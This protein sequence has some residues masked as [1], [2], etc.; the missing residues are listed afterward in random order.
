MGYYPLCGGISRNSLCKGNERG[1]LVYQDAQV[2]LEHNICEDNRSYGITY[3]DNAGGKAYRNICRRSQLGIA[4]G[5]K[6]RLILEEN[7]CEENELYGIFL[8]DNVSGK[9]RKNICQKN[10]VDGILITGQARFTFS[11]NICIKT[12]DRVLLILAIL[13]AAPL[14]IPV[15]RIVLTTS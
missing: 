11:N 3:K 15:S 13:E 12:R 7:T 6:V 5:H 2:V 9:A 1:I 8:C 4:V 14:K 10:E